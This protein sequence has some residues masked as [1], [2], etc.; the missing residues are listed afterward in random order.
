MVTT[1]RDA[2]CVFA[3]D[4]A[5]LLTEAARAPDELARLVARRVTGIPLEHLLGWAE[6]AGLRIAVAPGSSC[7]AAGPSCWSGRPSGTRRRSR[8]WSSCAAAPPRW[9][10]R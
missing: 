3:E 2:G 5:R 1:L 9:R 10:P 7:P 8:P 4:E 6:F